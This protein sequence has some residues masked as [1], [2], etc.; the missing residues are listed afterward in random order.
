MSLNR[1][2]FLRYLI[3]GGLGACF[4]GA[5]AIPKYFKE[6][7][8]G[9]VTVKR[10]SLVMGSVASFEVVADSERAGYE[11]IRKAVDVFRSLDKKLSMYRD[12]SEMAVLGKSAGRTPV[13]ISEDALEVLG[14]SKKISE[15][16]GGLFDVTIE[17]AMKSWGFR[18][19]PG[20]LIKE[21]THEELRKLE[22][23]IGSE[24]ISI[25][26]NRAYLEQKGMAVDLGGVAG[27]YALDK[28]I[29]E[30]KRSDIRAAY[31]NFSGDIHCFG[32]PLDGESWKVQILDPGTGQPLQESINLQ[33]RA[34]STSGA[35]E[36]RRENE[37]AS[38]GH[39]LNPETA[40]PVE[41][42]ASATA[43]HA[44]AMMADAWSTASYLGAEAPGEVETIFIK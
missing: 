14:F 40:R 28:A 1:K 24:K 12:D 6:N 3:T 19:E 15:S 43:I 25:T 16:T 38:W 41:P 37:G 4:G 23:L 29:E 26:G 5:S 9:L 22:Q 21:P 39:L 13:S 42:V 35:Y 17:P 34:L 11:A 32:Q 31:I 36:N 7:G 18:K 2:D 44:S 8:A 10:Q 30:M 27:G 20:D 33:E